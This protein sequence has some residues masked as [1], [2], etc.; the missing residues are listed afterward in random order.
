MAVRRELGRGLFIV[1]LPGVS[2]ERAGS[3]P[4]GKPGNVTGFTLA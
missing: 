2:A 3:I 4:I 1:F